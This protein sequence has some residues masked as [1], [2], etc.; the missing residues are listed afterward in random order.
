[1]VWIVAGLLLGGPAACSALMVSVAASLRDVVSEIGRD[2]EATTHVHL[3]YNVGGSGAL[4]R[5]IALGAPIDVFV[6]AGR[7]EIERLRAKRPDVGEPTTIARNRLVVVAPRT[8]PWSGRPVAAMLRAPAVTRIATGDPTI[9]PFGA[10]AKQALETAGLWETVAGKAVFAADVRQA[11]TY[12]DRGAVDAAI[13]YA[14]DARVAKSAVLL[15]DLPGG[16]D[17]EIEAVAVRTGTSAEA[18]RFIAALVS[19]EA[20][21]VFERYGFV[22]VDP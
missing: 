1:V 4:A 18:D 16:D 11:L 10:Y 8:S 9:V 7:S 5:Q 17:V 20:R 15:G 13:V 14:T 2:F 21:A 3:D 22:G 6:S 19:P 12:A